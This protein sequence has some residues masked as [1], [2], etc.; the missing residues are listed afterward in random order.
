ML[1]TLKQNNFKRDISSFWHEIMGE[2]TKK[3]HLA[4]YNFMFHK[5]TGAFKKI[6][7]VII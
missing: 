5:K 7:L 1:I 4:I 2:L 6:F 3:L